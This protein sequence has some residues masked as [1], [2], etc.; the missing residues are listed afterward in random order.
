MSRRF[1]HAMRPPWTNLVLVDQQAACSIDAI[2]DRALN[3]EKANQ[4]VS[5]LY[6]L[7]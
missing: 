4:R 5:A 7:T 1:C 6:R 3:K 2:R